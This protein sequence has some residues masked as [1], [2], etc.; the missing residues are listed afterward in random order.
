MKSFLRKLTTLS[1]LSA[2]VSALTWLPSNLA[3]ALTEQQILDK[4]TDIPV[5]L[6]V[7]SEGMVLPAGVNDNE[8]QIQ[9]VTLVFIHPAEA[10]AYI[11]RE[12][13]A[14]AG[15]EADA[16]IAAL[17]LRTVYEEV[18]GQPEQF[19]PVLY[20]PSSE[21][22]SAVSQLSD[23]DFRGVPLFTPFVE[24]QG[25][26][27]INNQVLMFFSFQDFQSGMARLIEENPELEGNVVVEVINFEYI[28]LNM[29]AEEPELNPELLEAIRFI[30]SSQALQVIQ[31]ELV[32]DAQS[33]PEA[34]GAE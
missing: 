29:L 19:D 18:T 24:N 20:I 21:S 11:D 22:I 8:A 4:L 7:D 15:F 25:Y 3:L 27:T 16:R 2:A 14:Q 1:F 31:N 30:P 6:I 9:P 17:S 34:D 33:T 23:Q 10:Q 12:G 13:E 5:F 32:E 26:P 28:L